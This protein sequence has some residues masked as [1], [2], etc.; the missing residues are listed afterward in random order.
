MCQAKQQNNNNTNRYNRLPKDFPGALIIILTHTKRI[1]FVL[2]YKGFHS[3]PYNKS[4]NSTKNIEGF[5]W[6]IKDPE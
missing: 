2:Y 4:N 5:L 3:T 6:I 1:H